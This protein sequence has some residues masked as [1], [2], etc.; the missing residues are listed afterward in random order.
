MDK[1]YVDDILPFGLC[2]VPKIINALAD[3]LE[4]CVSEEGVQH[5]F[6]YLDDFIVIG[7]AKSLEC[8]ENLS[9]LKRICIEIGVL[10]A[11]EKQ[12][13]PTSV[14][15][16]LGIIIDT[17]R[18]ELRLPAEKLRRLIDEVQLWLKKRSCTHREL[19]SLIGV[20]QHACKVIVPGRS[21]SGE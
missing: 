10:L 5:M 1:I 7:A 20:M 4:W 13:G 16:F 6:H 17:N 9:S 15:T 8:Y 14:I 19:E 11:E 21:S 18:R 12:D 3:G 2:S